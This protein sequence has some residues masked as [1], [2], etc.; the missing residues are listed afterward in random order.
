M[1]GQPTRGPHERR[2][3]QPTGRTSAFTLIELLVVIA[4]IAILAAL[5]LPALSRA[6][7][8]AQSTSCK[9]HLRQMGVAQ[10]MYVNDN[11]AYPYFVYQGSEVFNQGSEGPPNHALVY[12]PD[13]LQ[14][15]YSINWTNSAYHCP[16]YKGAVTPLQRGNWGSYAYNVRG[17]VNTEDITTTLGFGMPV[18]LGGTIRDPSAG[19]PLPHPRSEAEVVVPSEMFDIMD[20]R[21]IIPYS[22]AMGSPDLIWMGS[23][24]SG[25]NWAGCPPPLPPRYSFVPAGFPLSGF[26]LQHGKAFNV[27]FCDGHVAAV[28]VSNLS[29]PAITARNWNFDNQPHPESW[30]PQ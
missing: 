16:A 18:G 19:G 17:A 15:Y 2:G 25:W 11:N 28:L 21:E 9:N 1:R 10:R 26:P 27:L 29:D 14:P 4:I 6:K 8:Q 13:A 5:L 12:W 30:T 22:W 24:W 20:A 7:S 3:L 23:G